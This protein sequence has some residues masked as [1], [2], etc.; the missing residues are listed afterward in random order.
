M[1]TIPLLVMLVS[2]L[3]WLIMVKS[4]R[5]SD[6][7]AI[8]VCEILFAASSLVVLYTLSAKSIY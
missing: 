3:I 2:A 5:L 7:W 8:R 1:P 6:P 4:P